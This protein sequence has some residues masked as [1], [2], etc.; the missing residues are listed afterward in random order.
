MARRDG[1]ARERS[2]RAG[3]REISV[4]DLPGDLREAVEH[5][6]RE[7]AAEAC[8]HRVDGNWIAF[9]PPHDKKG[10]QPSASSFTAKVEGEGRGR[11]ATN[12][13]MRPPL[14]PPR[15]AAFLKIAFGIGFLCFHWLQRTATAT[16]TAT[17]TAAD[18]AED[19]AADTAADT[20][21]DTAADTATPRGSAPNP[22]G[23]DNPPRTPV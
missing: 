17:D 18:T 23:G 22:A 3:D 11:T 10:G 14:A 12:G 6:S 2:C 7:V 5:L 1:G 8:H 20:A 4:V 19:T 16:D 15:S 13:G 9:N 21:E